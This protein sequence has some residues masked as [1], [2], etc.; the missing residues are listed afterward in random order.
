MGEQAVGILFDLAHCSSE[1]G[2][3]DRL[4]EM[5]RTLLWRFGSGEVPP[6]QR[7]DVAMQHEALLQMLGELWWQHELQ[8]DV[9]TTL[10]CSAGRMWKAKMLDESPGVGL[11]PASKLH[12]ASLESLLHNLIQVW[13]LE[14]FVVT[15]LLDERG[16]IPHGIGMAIWTVSTC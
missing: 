3:K 12:E 9:S 14:R 11:T 10:S 7:G 16:D 4:L 1:G 2:Y 6:H 5:S 15:G 8:V 13:E